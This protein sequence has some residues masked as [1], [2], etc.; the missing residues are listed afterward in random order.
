VRFPR[1]RIHK[2]Y[3]RFQKILSQ[4]NQL[5]ARPDNE[6]CNAKFL[7][8]LPPSWLQVSIALKTKGGLDMISFDDLYNKLKSL[9]PDVRSSI[10]P[11]T[12]SAFVSTT[13]NPVQQASSSY[14][15]ASSSHTHTKPTPKSKSSNIMEDVLHSFVAEY[16]HQQFLAYE[17][18]EQLDPLEM[19]EMNLK[20]QLAMIS[21]NI[22]R[23]EN[24]SGRK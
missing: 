7:R 2:G 11:S 5:K 10:R 9:E 21:L 3:D 22:K 8:S 18:F 23:F 1:I 6:D 4:L 12:H 14:T 16:E 20:W 15:S 24:K 19:E 17:D 13:S